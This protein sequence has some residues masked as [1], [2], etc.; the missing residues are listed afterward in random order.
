MVNKV[1]QVGPGW[2]LVLLLVGLTLAVLLPT[3][4]AWRRRQKKRH[5]SMI[6]PQ[7]ALQQV[8]YSEAETT[9]LAQL[10]KAKEDFGPEDP[11]V[12]RPMRNLAILYRNQGKYTA[13]EPLLHRSL[14]IMEKADPE[15]IEISAILE[16]LAE[17]CQVQGRYEASE[18]ILLRSLAIRERVLGP[19][20]PSVTPLLEQIAMLYRKIGRT[21][22][23]R[24]F[25]ERAKLVRS[26][27]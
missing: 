27:N 18:L 3:M 6:T 17:I 12:V 16:Q 24:M 2:L 14:A 10:K 20:H 13:A 4:R 11:H 21:R 9:Y 26:R 8:P 22:D 5:G 23:A 25:E 7:S 19:D 15:N 1:A